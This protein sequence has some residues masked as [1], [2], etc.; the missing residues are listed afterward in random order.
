ML[1]VGIPS[2][3]FSEMIHLWLQWQPFWVYQCLAPSCV[4]VVESQGR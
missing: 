3:G 2:Q 4:S 1:F